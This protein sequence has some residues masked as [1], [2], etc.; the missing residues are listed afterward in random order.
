M[1]I[2]VTDLNIRIGPGTDY[3][4]TGKYTGVG[5]FMIVAESAGVGSAKGWGKLESGA[6]WCSLD[7]CEKI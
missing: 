4:R 1:R 7:Y 2:S 3:E 5:V 6:G